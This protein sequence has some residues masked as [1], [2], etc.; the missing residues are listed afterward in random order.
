MADEQKKTKNIV[1]L[2]AYNA[3][4]T[5]AR[6]YAEIPFD[7]VDEVILV[8]DCSNDETIKLAGELGIKHI[9][10]HAANRG[11]GGNQKTCYEHALN[12][13]ADIIIMLHPDY[14]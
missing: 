12:L 8:D 3:Q 13:G 6:T 9:F 14:Q 1:V 2:P 11:Y 4:H 5:L 7:V 10:S